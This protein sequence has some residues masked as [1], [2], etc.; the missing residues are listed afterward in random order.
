MG[1]IPVNLFA[2]ATVLLFAAGQLPPAEAAIPNR[3]PMPT[4]GPRFLSKG[5]SYRVVIGDTILLPCAVTDLGTYVVLWRRGISVLTADRMMVT[6]DPRFKLQEGFNLQLSNVMPQ[7]A[8]DYVCQIGDGDNRDQIHTVEILVPPSIRASPASGQLTARKGGTITLECKASGNPVPSIS[9]SRKGKAMPIGEKEGFSITLENVD[10][11]QAG[12]YQCTATNGVGEPVTVDMQLDVLYP[13][14]IEVEK[15]WV[16]AGEGHEAQ[17]ACTVH[18]EPQPNMLWYQDSFLLDPTNRRSMDTRGNKHM[19]TIHNVQNSDFGNYSCVAENSLGRAKKYIELSGRPSP[20]Q[21][22]SAPFSRSHSSYNLSWQIESYPPLEEVR[23]LYRKVMMNE[24]YQQPGKWHD[25]PLQPVNTGSFSHAMSYNIR[26]LHA[27]SV[28]E[29]IIQAKNRYGW[30]EVSDLYQFY[31]R[32]PDY[33]SEPS[34]E[35]MTLLAASS[36][37]KLHSSALLLS[38]LLCVS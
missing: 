10:R 37:W 33:P 17:L 27:N 30:N 31:T 9:W 6:R 35:D 18:G 28:Y 34:M 13:P 1:A 5:Q 19:L 20:A 11:H 23:L 22:H 4:D 16:H 38:L 12:V 32:G 2:A 29:E 15:S 21:F 3:G 8:G 26:H 36:S 7:D 14:E 24:T 25:V